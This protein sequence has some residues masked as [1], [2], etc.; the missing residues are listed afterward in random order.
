VL[1]C[2]LLK[3]GIAS[4][5]K[6]IK[7]SRARLGVDARSFRGRSLVV[8]SKV[9]GQTKRLILKN[10]LFILAKTHG[11]LRPLASTWF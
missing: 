11:G 7:V 4:E 3:S 9:L 10:H 8:P 5:L 2:I 6:G 1:S